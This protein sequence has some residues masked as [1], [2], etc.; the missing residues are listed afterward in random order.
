MGMCSTSAGSTSIAL[1]WPHRAGYARPA[2][3]L[4]DK[5]GIGPR[6]SNCAET[7]PAYWLSRDAKFRKNIDHLQSRMAEQGKVDLFL[8]LCT[9]FILPNKTSIDPAN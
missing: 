3:A 6:W 7:W 2:S 9:C 1:T 8:S 5:S 4:A